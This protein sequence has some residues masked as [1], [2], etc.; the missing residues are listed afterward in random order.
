MERREAE[1]FLVEY[2]ISWFHVFRR[3][4]AM[5][6]NLRVLV[7]LTV[8]MAACCISASADTVPL[9]VYSTPAAVE[10]IADLG[11]VTDQS[12]AHHDGQ[13]GWFPGSTPPL[14]APPAGQSG[15]G[16]D[17][18]G[19]LDQRVIY[20][21]DKRLLNT[22][23]VAAHGGFVYDIW[24]QRDASQ[25]TN[26]ARQKLID[27]DGTDSLELNNNQVLFAE[28]DH[29]YNITSS[30]ITD[31]NWHHVTAVFDTLGNPAETDDNPNWPGYFKVAGQMSLYLDGSL[32][33]SIAG[34]K[35]GEGDYDNVTMSIG[36]Y[37]PDPSGNYF[38]NTYG[39]FFGAVYSPQVWLG[40]SIPSV[41]EPS[42][43]VLS[44]VAGL[45]GLVCYAWR[46][47]R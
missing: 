38:R 35:N 45:A 27:Y 33:G 12:S 34:V 41:P 20:T 19:L 26:A 28:S 14:V 40:T 7:A 1:Q 17:M 24:F 22:P 3:S 21:N 31:T 25:A 47:R 2:H 36:R 4:S 23:D 8:V 10:H 11:T 42:T 32:V 5:C 29:T 46:K 44:V 6:A 16:L 9:F 37:M 13:G 15:N 18:D 43:A 39:K 30:A